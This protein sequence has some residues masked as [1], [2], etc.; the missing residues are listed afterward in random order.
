MSAIAPILVAILPGR[1]PQV[2]VLIAGGIIIGPEVLGWASA[3]DLTLVSNLGLGFLFLLAGYELDPSLLLERAGRL[4]LVAWVITLIVALGVVGL[5]EA[6]GLVKAFLPVSLALTTTAL[7]TL[8][9]I[10]RDHDMLSGRFGRYLF[11]SGAIG[12]MGPVICIALFL[13][14]Y[15]S[16]VELL[17]IAAVAGAAFL[18]TLLPRVL[19]GTRVGTAIDRGRHATGQTTL[20]LT[21]LLLVLLLFVSE[22]FGLDI[23]LGAFF[24]G[25]VL[26][27]WAPEDQESLVEKLD[28]V[29]Y[30]FFIPVFFVTSGINLDVD[31]IVQAPLR[32]LGFFV[33]LL[34]V[35]GAPA[36]LV[37]R[38]DLVWT[39]RVQLMFLT[40]TALPLLV[41]LTEI[42][43]QSGAMLPENAAALVGAGV[44]SV[45]LFPL[46]A[47]RLQP[48]ALE[49]EAGSPLDEPS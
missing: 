24:A 26:R 47:I 44:L 34:L 33:L 48:R 42:G 39:R 25:M 31:S 36:L 40:A 19:A 22:R 16:L 17:G 4:A 6:V 41:A 35:R 29:G 45:A 1:I 5:L 20:R 38:R 2:V 12:E 49:A 18:L 13:G 32:L 23:V 43:L 14:A 11:A 46:T 37:Y 15:N 27:R 28:A 21:V 8:I 10:L 30:G 9:P 7:G 3:S